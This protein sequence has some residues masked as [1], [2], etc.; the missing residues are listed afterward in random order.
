MGLLRGDRIVRTERLHHVVVHPSL[1]VVVQPLGIHKFLQGTLGHTVDTADQRATL[2]VDLGILAAVVDD[3][4]ETAN[5]LGACAF[6]KMDDGY[7]FHRLALRMSESK[8]PTA[9]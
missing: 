8:E 6:Y 5:S 1:G 4:I 2:V 3:R 7:Y 9:A